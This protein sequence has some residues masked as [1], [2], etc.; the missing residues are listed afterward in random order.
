LY[1]VDTGID[2]RLVR[3]CF[4][5]N[6]KLE[7]SKLDKKTN[8]ATKQQLYARE[9]EY[10]RQIAGRLQPEETLKQMNVNQINEDIKSTIRTATKKVCSKIRKQK[11]SKLSDDTIDMMQR[12]TIEKGTEELILIYIF[13]GHVIHVYWRLKN[14]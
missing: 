11:E 10:E 6:V 5:F 2:H 13:F 12:W 1:K 7:R 3:A 9:V 4:K 8:I 14:R